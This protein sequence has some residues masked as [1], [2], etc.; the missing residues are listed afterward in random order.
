MAFIAATTF[1][2]RT[3]NCNNGVNTCE[4]VG[5]A[6]SVQ[7][8]RVISMQAFSSIQG[9]LT[10]SPRALVSE[11]SSNGADGV[12]KA[13][14]QELDEVIAAVYKQT[15]GN[16][17]IMESEKEELAVFESEFR[18]SR[19][20]REFVRALAKSNAYTS[21]FLDGNSQY[22]F[23]ELNFKHL[24]GRG[25][26]SQAEIATHFAI[27][28]EGG[29]TAVID[30]IVDSEEYS[31]EFGDVV[32]PYCRFKGMYPTNEEFNR[33]LV[34][35]G[36]PSSSDKASKGRSKLCYSIATGGSQNWLSMTKG[37][38]FGTERGTGFQNAYPS[39]NRNAKTRVGTKIPGGVVFN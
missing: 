32:V 18:I 22:R 12:P 5:S 31:S 2:G 4:S 11:M 30:A 15:F 17:H 19:S 27:Y 34:L 13:N 6:V 35:K 26:R 28:A 21:R 14:P 24:L 39:R 8:G 1:G 23:F 16:A 38:P 10:D 7:N 20:V 3:L 9:V 25:P 29:F 37:L 33:M 36:T